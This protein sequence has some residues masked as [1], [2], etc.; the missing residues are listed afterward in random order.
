[1]DITNITSIDG[2]YKKNTKH[3]SEYFSEYSLFK[4]RI[5]VELKYIIQFTNP[6]L[7]FLKPKYIK[8]KA[9]Q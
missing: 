6:V 1:M 9:L 2:R 4:Y 3:L 7:Y 8:Y 5:Y